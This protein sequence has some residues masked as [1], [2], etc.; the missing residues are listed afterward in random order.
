MEKNKK[1][2]NAKKRN[3]GSEIEKNCF[4]FH[5]MQRVQTLCEK[6]PP[7]L[8]FPTF[9]ALLFPFG[10]PRTKKKNE[11]KK[12]EKKEIIPGLLYL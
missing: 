4:F 3:R 1:N 9:P 2:K 11:K 5:Y 6:S 10:L 7:G 8:E 12:K